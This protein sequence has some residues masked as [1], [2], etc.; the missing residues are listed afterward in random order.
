MTGPKPD[1]DSPGCEAVT[2]RPWS[3][4]VRGLWWRGGRIRDGRRVGAG[5]HIT[6]LRGARAVSCRAGR[7]G[8]CGPAR[9]H[10]CAPRTRGHGR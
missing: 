4:R 8:S 10:D 3:A 5:D 2:A 9:L 1:T 7:V 6:F